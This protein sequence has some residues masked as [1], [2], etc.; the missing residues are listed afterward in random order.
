[1]VLLSTALFVTANI[2]GIISCACIITAGAVGLS[3]VDN[4]QTWRIYWDC[5]APADSDDT[6]WRSSCNAGWVYAIVCFLVAV[7]AFIILFCEI[8]LLFFQKNYFVKHILSFT[9]IMEGHA[10]YYIVM[11]IVVLG[12]S[13]NLGIIFAS[14]ILFT[15]V[16]LMLFTLIIRLTDGAYAARGEYRLWRWSG[17]KH[18]QS[19]T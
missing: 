7:F 3:G 6:K 18:Q 4:G 15:G 12:I 9:K 16:V 10:C 19:E 8:V 1:M 13:A 14:W 11:G 17:S 2:L 5:H